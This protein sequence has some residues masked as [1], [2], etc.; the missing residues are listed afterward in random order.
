MNALKLLN[1]YK[2]KIKFRRNTPT[3]PYFNPKYSFFCSIGIKISGGAEPPKFTINQNSY[4]DFR[5]I[6][7]R[8]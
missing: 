8:R 6:V 2:N 3:P 5:W 1:T 4:G 7:K